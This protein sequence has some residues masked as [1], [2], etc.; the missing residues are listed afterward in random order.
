VCARWEARAGRP[1]QSLAWFE[2]FAMVRS[3]AIMTRVGVL[4]EQRGARPMLPLA[5]NPLID[6]L[7]RR[8]ERVEAS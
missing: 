6:Q 4:A 3:N 8:I 2:I 5:D 1:L 7:A